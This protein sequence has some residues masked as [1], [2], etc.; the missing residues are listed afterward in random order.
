MGELRQRRM[1]AALRN[2]LRSDSSVYLCSILSNGNVFIYLADHMTTPMA[3]M[4]PVA[5]IQPRIK[6]NKSHKNST[7]RESLKRSR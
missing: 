2:R 6:Q 1:R 5:I 4:E 3:V 7:E